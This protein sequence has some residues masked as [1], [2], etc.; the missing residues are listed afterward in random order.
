M[1]ITINAA[2]SYQNLYQAWIKVLSNQGAA[3]TDHVSVTHF[4]TDLETNLNKLRQEILSNTY[5]P[6]PLLRVSIPKSSGKGLRSLSIPSIRDRVLQTSVANLLT[7]LFELKFEEV[8][9]AYRTGRSVDQAIRMIVRLRDKGYEWVVDADIKSYF[10]EVD[11]A[12]L[13]NEVEKLVHDEGL[14]RL[15]RQWLNAT[16]TEGKQQFKLSKGIPQGSPLSPLLANLFLDQLDDA[17]IKKNLRIVR[18]ADDFLVLCKTE[19]RAKKALQITDEL[20]ESLKLRFNDSKT[21]ITQF[22]QGFQFLGVEFIRSFA[23]RPEVDKSSAS[24]TKRSAKSSVETIRAP[25]MVKR[26]TPQPDTSIAH[27]FKES[28]IQ[29]EQFP[30]KILSEEQETRELPEAINIDSNAPNNE[31][32]YNHDPILQTLFLTQHGGVLGKD[33]AR[34]SV[35]HSKH[36]TAYIPAIH[37]DQIMVFGNSQITTQAMHYCLEKR[38]PIYLLSA[39]GRYYGAIES[40]DT[41][42]VKLHKR[43]FL[44]SDDERFSQ[45]LACA[46]IEGKLRNSQLVLKRYARH[47][48]LPEFSQAAKRFTHIINKIQN[49]ESLDQLRGYEG[50]AARIYFQALVKTLNPKWQFSKRIKNPPTDPINALLSYGYTILFYNV[51]SLLRLHGLNP[52]VGFLHPIRM[53]HPAL[54]SDIIEE[55]RAII[56]DSVVF[57]LVFN[58][59]L[60]PEGF[61]WPDGRESACWIKPEAKRIF[62]KALEQKFNSKITHPHSGLKID[63]RRAIAHQIRQLSAVIRGT[64]IQYKAMVLR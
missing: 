52:H 64:E 12:L 28:G 17:L 60:S 1:D 62:I 53:G 14:L 63:Y 13:I 46:F 61:Y 58:E 41:D 19:K 44:V 25:R 8:S 30:E 36:P 23:F 42:P 49:A 9:F 56:V 54:V 26:N 45:T 29:T 43:Q 6:R 50:N 5:Q 27:A 4:E 7:P 3:G 18:Y 16:V 11:H 35:K 38:I 40:F 39:A 34:F 21:Q 31:S 55:F 57:N 20:L 37:V 59:R 24:E 51:Y 47:Q 32:S 10:D 22:N 48:Q 2:I 15:I 33:Q